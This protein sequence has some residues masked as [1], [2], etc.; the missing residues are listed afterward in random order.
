MS[1]V[2]SS[3][4]PLTLFQS[5]TGFDTTR[6]YIISFYLNLYSLSQAR[7]CTLKVL[8]GDVEVYTRVLTAADGPRVQNWKGPETTVPVIPTSPDQTVKFAYDCI[9]TGTGSASSALF[10]DDVSMAS[11]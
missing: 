3:N 5:V 1:Y 8:F 2:A 11:I 4:T 9:P 10:L 6:P 7:S